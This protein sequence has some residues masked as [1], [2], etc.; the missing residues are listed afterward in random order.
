MFGEYP[1]I[2]L[3]FRIVNSLVLLGLGYFIY[4]RFF[5]YRIEEKV[6]QKEA[7]FKG[8]E[9]QGHALEGRAGVLQQ[10]LDSQAQRAHAI[11]AKIDEWH[12]AVMA[13][14][15]KR[16]HELIQFAQK[17]AQRTEVKNAHIQKQYFKHAVMPHAIAQA[18]KEL[19]Q[20][21]AKMFQNQAYLDAQIKKLAESR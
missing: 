5:K 14:D 15:K 18:Q 10:Q 3:F 21:Y 11:T 7:L 4:R 13:A 12:A 6:N 16:M 9:E 2:T 8:L 17:A 19:E 20:E 1:L